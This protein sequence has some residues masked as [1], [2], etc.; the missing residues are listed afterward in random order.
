[1]S[2]SP[3]YLCQR[4]IRNALLLSPVGAAFALA[5]LADILTVTA[6]TAAFATTSL[7]ANITLT[8]RRLLTTLLT[9]AFAAAGLLT[10]VT[11]TARGLLAT[12]LTATLIIF[13]IVCHF[14]S[15]LGSFV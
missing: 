1:L 8:A 11:L 7:L 2:N 15:L 10:T 13:S 5:L 4:I 6:T 3:Q 9:A 12:L 14:Y